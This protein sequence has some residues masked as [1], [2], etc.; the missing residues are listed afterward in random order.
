MTVLIALDQLNE[1]HARW[2]VPSQNF[3]NCVGHAGERGEDQPL[4]ENDLK[5]KL[6]P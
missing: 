2:P 5:P 6:S 4:F 3:K 1:A